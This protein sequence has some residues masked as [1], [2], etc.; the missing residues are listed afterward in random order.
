MRDTEIREREYHCGDCKFFD[1]A[2]VPCECRKGR[3][4]AAYF[5]RICESFLF[6]EKIE[7][8]S[9]EDE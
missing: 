2:P 3:G 1:D 8:A 9:S 6:R 4:Q 7:D 5:R